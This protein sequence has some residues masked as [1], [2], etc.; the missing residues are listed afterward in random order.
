MTVDAEIQDL[1]AAHTLE[2][3]DRALA[4]ASLYEFVKQAWAVV[5]PGRK[6]V[7]G[8]HIKAICDH[9][10]AVTEGR[11][12]KLIVNI[13]PRCMKSLIVGV[14]WPAWVWIKHPEKRFN[15][16]S[17]NITL[18]I[19][20]SVKCR[21]VIDSRWYQ[22]RWY[23][24]FRMASDQNA[25]SNFENNKGGFR[26]CYSVPG[27]VMG[28][29]ADYL[30]CDDPNSSMDVFYDNQLELANNWFDEAWSTR[31]EDYRTACMVLVMQRLSERDVAG[32]CLAQGGWEHLC[33]PMQFEVERRCK[34]SIFEDWRT[35][36]GELLWPERIGE[37]D[38]KA[39]IASMGSY[40]AAGQLQQRPA[41]RGGGMFKREWF[42]IVSAA[43]AGTRDVRYWDRAATQDGGDYT[44]GLRMGKAANGLHYIKDIVR[45][46]V[47]PQLVERAIL[48]TAT[49][50]GIGVTICLEQD[51]GQ[52]GKSDVA[53]LIRQLVGKVVKAVPVTKNKETRAQP[54]MSQA[55]AQNIKIVG[56][57]R[58]EAPPWYEAFISE[59]TVFPR[60]SHDDQVDCLSG[61]FNHLNEARKVL[62]AC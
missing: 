55:E 59:I 52:A 37:S 43:P 58:G 13:P 57:E 22:E 48:N 54:V 24:S 46:Q 49:A 27:D 21:R 36:E 28:K 9:Y 35:V 32:H 60:G 45:A 29:G 5:E 39:M 14:F 40:A 7:D 23:G 51:P 18:A 47:S 41:P 3:V 34:T 8:A 11:M 15:F 38:V 33:L 26:A 2:D 62:F 4:E 10:E 61:A 16:A 1:I 19:R 44:V 6:F 50:D 25:K 30:V 56:N 31:M 53:Y 17:C 20:D 12:R 42:E